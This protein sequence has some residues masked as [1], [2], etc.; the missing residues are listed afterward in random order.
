M[1]SFSD[2]AWLYV[3]AVCKSAIYVLAISTLSD[4][5]LLHMHV[6]VFMK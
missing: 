6:T 3:H 5:E 2:S 4:S 1:S